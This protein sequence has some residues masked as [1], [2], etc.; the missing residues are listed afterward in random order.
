VR[1]MAGATFLNGQHNG[2]LIGG[3]RTD[4]THPSV[5]IA[6]DCIRLGRRARFYTVIGRWPAWCAPQAASS[7]GN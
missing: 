1:D 4:K 7:S 6:V 5:V 2:V 3:T